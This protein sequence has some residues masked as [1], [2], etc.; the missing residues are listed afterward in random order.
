MGTQEPLWAESGDQL[1][2]EL[3]AAPRQL[4]PTK[5][6]FPESFFAPETCRTFRFPRAPRP[7]A[8]RTEKIGV[9][10]QKLGGR[11]SSY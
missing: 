6:T 8:F 3:A 5:P 4:P 2:L 1:P 10:W 9:E 11:R 7:A